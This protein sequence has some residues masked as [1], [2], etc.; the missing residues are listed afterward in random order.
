MDGDLLLSAF[1]FSLPFFFSGFPCIEKRDGFRKN[2]MK[3][4]PFCT[5]FLF[6]C[7]LEPL[8]WETCKQQRL[9]ICYSI[10]FAF[11]PPSAGPF[12]QGFLFE[13]EDYAVLQLVG[14]VGAVIMPHNLYL[15]SGIC[16]ER[17]RLKSGFFSKE[18]TA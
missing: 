1:F 4:V 9:L 7:W 18:K 5:L 13:C 6:I 2:Y 16:K 14:T 10:N 11:M 3:H 8:V 15:H 12:L 17:Q